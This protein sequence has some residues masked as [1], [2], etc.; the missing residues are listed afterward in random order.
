MRSQ[1]EVEKSDLTGIE[2]VLEMK[3]RWREE[4]RGFSEYCANYLSLSED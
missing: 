4:E 1:Y 2:R 3:M